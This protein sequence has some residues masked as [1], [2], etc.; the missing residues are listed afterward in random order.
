M[1]KYTAS[2]QIRNL[3]LIFLTIGLASS[4]L[5]FFFF[6][7]FRF[8]SELWLHWWQHPMGIC[9]GYIGKGMGLGM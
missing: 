6:L 2:A 3:F 1:L 5:G 4:F 8:G 9:G 7:F